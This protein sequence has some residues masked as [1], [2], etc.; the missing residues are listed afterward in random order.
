MVEKPGRYVGGEFGSV[1]PA[2]DAKTNIALAFPDTYEI[3]MS[4]MGLSILYEIVNSTKDLSAERCYMP[5][6]DMIKMLKDKKLPLLALESMKPVSDFDFLGFSLQYEL[7]YTNILAMLDLSMIPRRSCNRKDSHP[8][9][10]AGGPVAAASEPIAPFI[11]LVVIGDGEQ[12]LVD[13][14]NLYAVHKKDGKSRTEII[15]LLAGLSFVYAPANVKRTLDTAT[16]KMVIATE[17]S[18]VTPA[19]VDSLENYPTGNGPVPAVKAV[20]DRY[21][22][23][24]ARGC[25]EGCRFCQAGYLYRPVRERSK[26]SIREALVKATDHLG[27]DEVSLSALSAADHSQIEGIVT[28]IGAEYIKKRV[29]FSVPSLRDYG[30]SDS[31]IDVLAKLRATGVTLAPEAGSQRLRDVIN[32]NISQEDLIRATEKFFT[33]GFSRIKLYFMLGLPTE[34]DEDLIAIIDLGVLLRSVGRRL[35]GKKAEII[36]SVSTFVPKPFTPFEREPM[37]DAEEIK[38]RHDILYTEARRHRIKVKTHNARMSIMEGI[39]T[40]GDIALADVLEKAV[41]L[42]AC[43]DGWDDQF[44]Y[45]IWDEVLKDINV[46]GYLDK[47]PDS[48]KVPWDI[49]KNGVTKKYRLQERDKAY[50]TELTKPCGVYGDNKIFECSACGVKCNPGSLPVRPSRERQIDK[51]NDGS[52]NNIQSGDIIKNGTDI[53]NSQSII[54]RKKNRTPGKVIQAGENSVHFRMEVAFYGRQTYLGHLDTMT[55]LLRSFRRAGLNLWYTEGFH[56]KPKIEAPPPVPLGTAALRDPFDVWLVDP[57]ADKEILSRLK[58]ALPMDLEVISINQ[59]TATGKKA[60]LSNAFNAA[61]YVVY[62]KAVKDHVEQALLKIENSKTLICTRTRKNKTKVIDIKPFINSVK[63]I[64][65][66]S[67]QYHLPLTDDRIAV[68]MIL[69]IPGSGGTRPGEVIDAVMDNYTDELWIV[70]TEWLNITP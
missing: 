50:K 3:G 53:Q 65:T 49:V 10:I 5:W 26:E 37:I 58:K 15:N 27:F 13:I 1:I 34:R 60:K 29:S 59:I 56:P 41:D 62:I 39:F 55:H 22:V 20:F 33:K 70:R 54:K 35:A 52:K 57:P 45:A 9:V 66:A 64:D 14:M 31:V 21:S 36:I 8:V 69:N 47:I 44:D 63:I 67:T 38:R 51:N 32:K 19:F 28:E 61:K 30:L 6:P 11:D 25:T 43:F 24:I 42:G 40:R 16:K 4:H 2:K 46:H 12:S 68:E 7:S 18:L 48:S 17:D 23:E